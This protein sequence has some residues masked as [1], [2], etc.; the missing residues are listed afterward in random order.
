MPKNLSF[1]KTKHWGFYVEC[2]T[3]NL[4]SF[5]FARVK[6]LLAELLTRRRQEVV[7]SMSQSRSRH[8]ILIP[9][10]EFTICRLPLKDL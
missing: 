5:R 3:P 4:N 7:R 6:P 1:P 10:F 9:L 8:E 2:V